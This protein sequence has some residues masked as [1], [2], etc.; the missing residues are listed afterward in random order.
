MTTDDEPIPEFDGLTFEQA[1]DVLNGEPPHDPVERERMR[2]AARK[3]EKLPSSEWPPFDVLWDLSAEGQRFSLDGVTRA[4][5]LKTYPFGFRLAWVSIGALDAKLIPFNHRTPEEVWDVGNNHKAAR[6]LLEWIEGRAISPPILHPVDNRQVC[7]G[8]G[9]H[10][11][12]V[13]RAKGEVFVPI[14]CDHAEWQEISERL[15][16]FPTK[17]EATQSL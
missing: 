2:A 8:G 15:E 5:F 7:L 12:A 4:D 16:L 3:L 11:L 9:N 10:R 14:L 13:A 6:V 1:L 17:E